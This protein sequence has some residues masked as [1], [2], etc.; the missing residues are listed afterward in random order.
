MCKAYGCENELL[1]HE[2][3]YVLLSSFKAMLKISG[4]P[5]SVGMF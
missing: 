1:Y 4:L 5:L 3:K 2:M